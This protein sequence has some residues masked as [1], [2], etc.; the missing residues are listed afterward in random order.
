MGSLEHPEPSWFCDRC[1]DFFGELNT[2]ALNEIHCKYFS[3]F[4]L[5]YDNKK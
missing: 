5:F 3:L 2:K 4:F 1:M